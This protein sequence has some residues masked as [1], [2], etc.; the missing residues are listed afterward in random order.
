MSDIGTP[1]LCMARCSSI[2]TSSGPHRLTD[3]T[4]NTL[5]AVATAVAKPASDSVYTTS[6][7]S[8]LA[9]SQILYASLPSL[10]KRNTYK[11]VGAERFI[12]SA[13]CVSAARQVFAADSPVQSE[14]TKMGFGSA[15]PRGPE[16]PFEDSRLRE[17]ADPSA[18]PAL[19][20]FS[21]RNCAATLSASPFATL[22]DV[23]SRRA[24]PARLILRCLRRRDSE[25][26][27][28]ARIASA[29]LD[30][31]SFFSSPDASET[32]RSG[33]CFSATTDD[34]LAPAPATDA[35]AP[36]CASITSSVARSALRASALAFAAFS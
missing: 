33:V 34:F 12:T 14:S 6:A 22:C 35:A 15:T 13:N 3:F 20:F 23:P 10:K 26:D 7:S 19:K 8:S 30:L 21:T 1:V 17:D 9:C 11:L 18:S 29:A 24:L 16:T 2:A 28:R 31:A 27:A 5:H 4:P 36:A 32:V 25:D